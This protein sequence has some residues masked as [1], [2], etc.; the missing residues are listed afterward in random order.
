MSCFVILGSGYFML[1]FALP[2]VGIITLA[3]RERE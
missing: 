2:F 1:Q 3:E